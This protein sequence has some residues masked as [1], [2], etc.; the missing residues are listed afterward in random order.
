MPILKEFIVEA[1]INSVR[2]NI[3]ISAQSPLDA[4]YK[5]GKLHPNGT[6]LNVKPK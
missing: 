3:V 6:F 2:Q 4:K 5:F 1:K